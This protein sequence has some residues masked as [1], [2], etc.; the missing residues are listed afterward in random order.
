[1]GSLFLFII[2]L[3]FVKFLKINGSQ[4]NNETNGQIKKPLYTKRFPKPKLKANFNFLKQQ[5]NTILQI[6]ISSQYLFSKKTEQNGLPPN[7]QPQETQQQQ[8]HAPPPSW[9]R[10]AQLA[11]ASLSSTMQIQHYHRCVRLENQLLIIY[12]T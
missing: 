11:H 6:L 4:L 8:A 12:V 1:M 10:L 7:K 9:H 2:I 5:R 3:W